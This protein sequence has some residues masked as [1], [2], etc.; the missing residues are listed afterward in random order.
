MPISVINYQQEDFAQ[1][2]RSLISKN[3]QASQELS[4]KVAQIIDRVKEHGDKEIIAICNQFD[5]SDFKSGQDLIVNSSGIKQAKNNIKAELLQAMQ[6]AYQRIYDYHLR[7]MPQDFT[8]Q[9]KLGNKLGNRWR[10]IDSVAAYV[11]GGT[12]LYPSSVLMTVVPAVVA[13]VKNIVVTVPS[14]KGEINDCVL[15]ACDICGI[16]T[17]Y[18]MGGTAAVAALAYGTQTINKV[19]KIVGPGNSFVALAKKQLFGQVGIDML[20]GPSDILVIADNKA[21]PNWIA[22][23]LL[24]QLE[25]G[26]DSSAILVTDDV[27]LADSVSIAIDRLTAE[28]SRKDIIAKSLKNSAIIIVNSLAEDAPKIADQ[29]APEHLEIITDNA[30]NLAQKINNA[31]AIFLGEYSPEA[32]GDYVAGPNHTLPTMGTARFSGGLSVFDFLKRTSIIQC[33]KEGF[34]ELQKATAILAE[35]EGLEAHKLSVTIRDEN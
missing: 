5:G 18:K 22:A 1:R 23:D 16:E 2:L 13:G 14:V 20:A 25:H 9:D 15:A 27:S 26:A 12:A 6:L 24:S 10:A 33:C 35:T 31:G 29:I 32:I 8:Y 34:K 21:N 4:L 11:P 17:I 28:L 19:D 7:Q 3:S 30:E